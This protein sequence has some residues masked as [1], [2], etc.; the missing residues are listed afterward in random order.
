MNLRDL[1]TEAWVARRSHWPGHYVGDTLAALPLAVQN[2][3][4]SWNPV[5]IAAMGSCSWPGNGVDR[6]EDRA[7]LTGRSSA[8]RG[9]GLGERL[10]R[11]SAQRNGNGPVCE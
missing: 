4:G 5:E 6:G 3:A 9:P 10:S 8:L 2:W 1:P 7:P 11:L